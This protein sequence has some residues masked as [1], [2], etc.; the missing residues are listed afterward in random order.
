MPRVARFDPTADARLDAG[1]RAAAP[2]A[3]APRTLPPP[4][5]ETA[6]ASASASAPAERLAEPR[7][8]APA[9]VPPR[10]NAVGAPAAAD[11]AQ[12]ASLIDP[13]VDTRDREGRTALFIACEQGRIAQVRA[14]LARGANPNAADAKGTTPLQAAVAAKHADVAAVL[15]RAGGH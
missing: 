9:R 13:D 12:P 11:A 15:R 7:K 6:P 10:A 4:A 3:A 5:T 1:S 14:L 2:P 8:A